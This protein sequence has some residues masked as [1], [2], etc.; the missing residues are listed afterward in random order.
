MMTK[1]GAAPAEAGSGTEFRRKAKCHILTNRLT[2]PIIPELHINKRDMELYEQD[3]EDSYGKSQ[4]DATLEGAV[5]QDYILQKV[6]SALL[7]SG[8]KGGLTDGPWTL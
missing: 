5:N 3:G 7:N 2:R 8:Y 4:A 6:S 1:T